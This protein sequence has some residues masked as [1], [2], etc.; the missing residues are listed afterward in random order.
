MNITQPGI[1]QIPISKD[2]KYII[3]FD[4][5]NE[6]AHIRIVRKRGFNAKMI[7]ES[8]LMFAYD[9]SYSYSVS[10]CSGDVIIFHVMKCDEINNV[11]VEEVLL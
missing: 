4:V 11:V 3:S 1:Y 2:G 8:S 6:S 5:V 7:N 10:L 9:D